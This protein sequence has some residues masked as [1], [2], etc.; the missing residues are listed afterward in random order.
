MT[1]HRRR[2]CSIALVLLAIVGLAWA[3]SRPRPSSAETGAAAWISMSIVNGKPGPLSL[4]A[5]HDYVFQRITLAVDNRDINDS[6]GALDWLRHQS[7]FRS[8][9][10]D[11]VRKSR[12]Y[13]HNYRESRPDA[14][15]YSHVF[16]GAEW[17]GKSNALELT[18]LDA[19]GKVVGGPLRLTNEDFL[20]RQRQQDFDMIKA[21]YRYENFTRHKDLASAKTKRAV[22]KIVFAVQTNLD[23]RLT[24]PASAHALRVVW[25]KKPQ[26]P[27]TFPIRLVPPTY[28]YGAKLQVRIEPE[29]PVYVPGYTI[30]AAFSVV[31]QNGRPLKFS[32]F[33]KNGIRQI[34]IHLDGPVQDPTYYHEEW[35]SEFGKRN[36]HHFRAPALGFGTANESA[37]T[38]LTD[39]PLD[40]DGTSMVVELHVPKNLPNDKFGS[41]EIGAT[42]WRTYAS[43]DWSDRLDRHIQVG[44]SA[45]THFETFGCE[46][47]HAPNT[48]MDVGLLIP[49]MVGVEK[50]NVASIESCVMCHDNSRNGSRRLNKYLHL[51]HENRATFPAGKDSC[52][53]C[54]L[55]DDR[56][57]KGE[58]P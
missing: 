50:L 29:K 36:A 58:Y 38:A 26:E 31:D 8:L 11:G 22:A 44:Q 15:L 5:G 10:W 47:C 1:L 35:L 54:H 2:I 32:E 40:S 24:I 39:P 56:I 25:D 21:E 55:T 16:D 33:G 34:N 51:I 13:W 7:D 30:R 41:F 17:M 9:N 18:V 20:N 42:V 37:N 12:E 49:P 28:A 45:P 53:L 48:P 14:D 52:A 46:N 43:Q 4:I 6:A 3:T 27:Y 23:K 19:D 57:T